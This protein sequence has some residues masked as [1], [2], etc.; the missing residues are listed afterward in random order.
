MMWRPFRMP[1]LA[2]D[3]FTSAREDSEVETVRLGPPRVVDQAHIGVENRCRFNDGSSAIGRS[4]VG[5]DDLVAVSRVVLI[6]HGGQTCLDIS[7]L[8]NT[9]MTTLTNGSS[10]D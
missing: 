7:L 10:L 3:E 1:I 2:R 9:G 5:N 4:A 6:Q 8:V